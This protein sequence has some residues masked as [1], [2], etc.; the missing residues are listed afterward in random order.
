[1]KTLILSLILVLSL[2]NLKAQ[3]IDYY[4]SNGENRY[5]KADLDVVLSQLKKRMETS[6]KKI[7]YVSA[8][9]IKQEQ[10]GDTTLHYIKLKVSDKDPA[11]DPFS[12]LIGKSLEGAPYALNDKPTLVNFW[13][14][15]CAPCIDEMP[16]L[17][18]LKQQYQDKFNFV[19]VTYETKEDVETFLKEH[20]FSFEHFT[21]AEKFINSIGIQ[22]YP[23][24]IILD[25]QG[26]VR[27]VMSGIAYA[28]GKDGELVIGTGEELVN[29]LGIYLKD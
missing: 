1:M 15:K 17:N 13:F 18:N 24:N 21:D 16:V 8:E 29:A 5:T 14:T 22:A 6:M 27:K 11:K 4:T 10:L 28:P 3:E 26:K 25:P 12:A 23:K 7:M 2:S 9:D 20:E 19:S